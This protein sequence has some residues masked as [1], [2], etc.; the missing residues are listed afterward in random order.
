MTSSGGLSDPARGGFNLRHPDGERL[1]LVGATT[2]AGGNYD[3]IRGTLSDG[4]PGPLLSLEGA[5][6]AALP[7]AGG[8]LYLPYLAGERSPFRD[9]L[10]RAAFVGIGRETGRGELV[11][12]VLEGVAFSLRSIHRA[13]GGAGARLERTTLVGGGARSELWRRVVASVFDCPVDV[14]ERP[15]EAGLRG[16]AILAGRRLGWARRWDREAE[17]FGTTARC[18]PEP[19]WTEVYGRLQPVFD[20]LYAA[21]S[22][23]YRALAGVREGRGLGAE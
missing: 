14:P 23:A 22:P 16:A 17:Y 2:T 5:A 3:W 4:D 21:L 7:G 12:A 1:I 9:P 8:V 18:V 19:A 11:R 13:L 10:A 15:E 6:A 20:E